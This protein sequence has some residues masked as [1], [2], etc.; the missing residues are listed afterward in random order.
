MTILNRARTGII[1]GNK[2]I[3]SSFVHWV[4]ALQS[5]TAVCKRFEE[6]AAKRIRAGSFDYRLFGYQNMELYRHYRPFWLF[7]SA[8]E[9]PCLL[10]LHRTRLDLQIGV[11]LEI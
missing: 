5:S 10:Y 4:S 8:L 9:S 3:V 1:G 11:V 7:D 6:I 2:Q